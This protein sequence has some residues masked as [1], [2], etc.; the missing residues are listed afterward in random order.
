MRIHGE[1]EGSNWVVAIRAPNLN[2]LNRTGGGK[3]H[4]HL[5]MEDAEALIQCSEV[6][7]SISA[8]IT[9]DIDLILDDSGEVAKEEVK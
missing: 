4:R 9:E 8:P 2:A 1:D 3:T 5:T 7:S 6:L